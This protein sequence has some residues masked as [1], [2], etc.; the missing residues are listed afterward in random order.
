M[1]LSISAVVVP[2]EIWVGERSVAL[3]ARV[4]QVVGQA[5]FSQ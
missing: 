5:P 1:V 4:G 3:F 2:E